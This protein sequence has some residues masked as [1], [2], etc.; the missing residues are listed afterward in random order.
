MILESKD[1]EKEIDH[2]DIE[3]FNELQ[4]ISLDQNNIKNSKILI[5]ESEFFKIIGVNKKGIY[6]NAGKYQESLYDNYKKA[7]KENDKGYISD[8]LI[9]AIIFKG[10]EN[11][12]KILMKNKEFM[13]KWH[14]NCGRISPM[15][16][17]KNTGSIRKIEIIKELI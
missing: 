5:T 6:K 8:I 4:F 1:L 3:N 10:H 12:I 11:L 16:I 2:I 7:L 14:S 17:L 15:T 13:K 9:K